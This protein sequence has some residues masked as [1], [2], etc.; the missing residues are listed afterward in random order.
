[1]PSLG[2]EITDILRTIQV[3]YETTNPQKRHDILTAYYS[4]DAFLYETPLVL[5][6]DP[7]CLE[8]YLGTLNQRTRVRYDGEWMMSDYHEE[9]GRVL[10][11]AEMRHEYTV[12]FM[13]GWEM[14]VRLELKLVRT[15]AGKWMVAEHREWW[16]NGWMSS[17]WWY[18][19]RSRKVLTTRLLLA[20]LP[21]S[22]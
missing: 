1:M 8:T 9:G 19:Q 5:M 4:H 22:K 6:E 10:V 7:S 21:S 14:E 3:L 11:S 2:E 15:G 18:D 16:R 20:C 13:S 12:E 17:G